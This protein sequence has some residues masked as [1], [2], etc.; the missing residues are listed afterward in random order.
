MNK[1][2]LYILFFISFSAAAKE[3][4]QLLSSIEKQLNATIEDKAFLE[5]EK[6]QLQQ[7]EKELQEKIKERKRHVL[8]RLRSLYYLKRYQWGELFL[9]NNLN[10]ID[11]DVKILKN[12]N[13]YDYE[14]FNEYNMALK[15]LA[16]A[17]KNLQD[18]ENQIQKNVENLKKEQAQFL[19]LEN[20]RIKTLQQDHRDSLLL[21]KGALERPLSAPLKHS[22]G[23]LRDQDNQY[24]L[25]NRGELYETRPNS[26]VKA[27]GPGTIIFSDELERWRETLIIQH[28][29]NY[30]S[31]YAGL[32]NP[33]K[34]I[35]EQVEKGELIGSTS[36]ESFY[37][38]LRHFDNPINPH[39]WYR[40]QHD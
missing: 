24:Y 15:L 36:G 3:D 23:S 2:V 12:L 7:R 37:F 14:L 39:A 19:T 26:P 16:L 17:R 18:T 21:I 22:F 30:Y 38:E 31:V 33:N 40:S 13:R 20:L 34:A 35:G 27:I 25:V 32:N 28:S 1:F 11:R 5:T 29:D 10:Q 9:N 8:K 4:D 6:F